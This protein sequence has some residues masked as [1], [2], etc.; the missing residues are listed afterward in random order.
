MTIMEHLNNFYE[1]AKTKTI[2]EMSAI[3]SKKIQW[4][5]RR[6]DEFEEPAEFERECTF[7]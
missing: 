1:E 5:V 7:S 2:K 4:H 6:V 3:R